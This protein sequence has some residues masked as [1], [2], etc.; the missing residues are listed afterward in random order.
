[1]KT[2]D[3][4]IVGAGSAGCVLANRLTEDQRHPATVLLLEAGGADDDP[5]I[6]T[7]GDFEELQGTEMDWAYTVDVEK[8]PVLLK[9]PQRPVVPWPRGKGVGGS[10]S[11]NALLYVRGNRR[12]FDH[13]AKLGN[14]GWSYQEVLPYFKK[15]ESNQRPGISSEFHGKD[16]PLVV[17]DL[18]RPN[19]SSRAFIA[20]A[21]E[22]GY[23]RVK[24]FN[25]REQTGGVG[26]YQVTI[27]N[28]KRSSAATAYLNSEVRKRPNLT[29]A[30]YAQATR[31]LFVGKRAVAVEF[32]DRAGHRVVERMARANQ[33]IIVC[34]GAVDSPKLLLLSGLG[35][36]AELRSL[37][38]EVAHDLQG[39]GRNLQDHP[40]AA[41]L[42]LYKEG[43][44]SEPPAAGGV[45]AGL[46]L[47]TRKGSDWPDLQFHFTHKILGRPPAPPA[48]AGYMI[49]ST[50]VKPLSR[51][52]IKL[53]SKKPSDPPE[54][55][56]NYL[57]DKA[58]LRTL[59][60]GIKI[61]RQIGGKKAFDDFRQIEA[62]PGP[63]AQTDEQIETFIRGSAI[64][65]YHPVG[66][67]KMGPASDREAVVDS[68][69]RVHGIKGL[70]VVDAS[71][72]PVITTGN[73]NAATVM[74]AERAAD[75]IKQDA[76]GQGGSEEQRDFLGILERIA[77]SI[78]KNTAALRHI[79]EAIEAQKKSK[80]S[81]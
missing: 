40:I 29:I 61:A 64:G 20:A 48:D 49:V 23:E 4:I 30:T 8:E 3:Y 63:E 9:S 12:D 16:G 37:G 51:G 34:C 7:P 58:D 31:L 18:E 27:K 80:G 52:W 76:L 55:R 38:I 57:S 19:S 81:H 44:H 5:R 45:E 39:V 73:T 21:E 11:I 35:P 62:A 68:R 54:I 14:E 66:T 32:E 43:K 65:L 69:L 70:R 26:F 71:I 60:E 59:V 17:S 50:L 22:A 24:D 67:C 15:S 10:R 41:V 79:A 13:W 28:G 46:F 56:P 33:E 47:D 36:A 2:Y 1:M 75:Y 53:R 72:M 74:I 6:H 77:Q 25:D 42:Y 78:D